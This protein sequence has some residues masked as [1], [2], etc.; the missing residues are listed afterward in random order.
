[1]TVVRD[2]HHGP[3]PAG[4]MVR[5][6]RISRS[7]W[8]VGSSSSSRLGFC[9]VMRASTRRA[10]SPPEK[11]LPCRAP[12]RRENRS[13]RGS[14]EAPVRSCPGP[15]APGDRGAVI[16]AQGFE[17]M[18]GEVADASPGAHLQLARQRRVATG[19]H[20]DEGGLAGAVATEQA[21][22][23]PF[24]TRLSFDLLEDHLCHRNR[25]TG[26]PWR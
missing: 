16:E 5:A 19:E 25:R 13:C 12:C 22:A 17:L 24:G 6:W 15:G 23:R 2:H 26:S 4:A 21:D 11:G 7:R 20:L 9:Q 10:F 14:C 8:L 18:L 1:M 3:E